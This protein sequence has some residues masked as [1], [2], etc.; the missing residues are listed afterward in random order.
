VLIFFRL[1]RLVHAAPA[2][3]IDQHRVATGA[4]DVVRDAAEDRLREAAAPVRGHRHQR[5]LHAGR[6]LQDGCR[7]VVASGDDARLGL[8]PAGERLQL[9]R[10]LVLLG[11]AFGDPHQRQ[12]R[13]DGLRDAARVR[14][15]FL[16]ERGTVDGYQ[17]S[18]VHVVRPLSAMVGADFCIM[19]WP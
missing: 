15:H 7:H 1:G 18:F 19:A 17:D 4:H 3:T 12:L 14:Q 11:L 5:P 13:T 16:G 10:R 8:E 9:L 6:F 2:R